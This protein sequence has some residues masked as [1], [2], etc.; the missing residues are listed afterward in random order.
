MNIFETVKCEITMPDVAERYGITVG[1]NGFVN[2]IFHNDKHPSMKLYK[3]HYHCFA[4]GAHG[5]VI[6]FS[7]QLFGLSPYNTAKKIAADFGITDIKAIPSKKPYLSECETQSLLKRH[8]SSLEGNRDK[9][10]PCSPDEE[11]HPL[12]VEAVQ[13][14]P[15]YEY[16][17]N[18]LTSSSK[19]E[20]KLFIKEERRFF[21]E[22]RA[23]LR[24]AGMVV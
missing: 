21:N 18:I 7:A 19:E 22:L 3:D 23:R 10:R 5:D 15:L 24:N 9:Y 16:Y 20:R 1:R 2:C 8:I 6:S 17:L 11:L 14:L 12:Y 4:C 13:M